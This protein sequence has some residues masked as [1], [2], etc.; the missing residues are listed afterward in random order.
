MGEPRRGNCGEIASVG[1]V[2][3]ELWR[4]TSEVNEDSLIK[5][6]KGNMNPLQPVFVVLLLGVRGGVVVVLVAVSCCRRLKRSGVWSRGGARGKK[7]GL[8]IALLV[9]VVAVDNGELVPFPKRES[10]GK[11]WG[12]E[13]AG[14]TGGG[15][16]GEGG[17]GVVGVG[18]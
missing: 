9:G 7:K 3:H 17:F 5:D 11:L 16:R 6:E 14:D 10:V 1:V 13:R 15:V 18:E 2:G 12:E 4:V 8:M